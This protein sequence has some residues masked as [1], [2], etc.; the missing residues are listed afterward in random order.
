[1]RII[2]KFVR[3]GEERKGRAGANGERRSAEAGAK[4]SAE[5]ARQS[6]LRPARMMSMLFGRG[7][8]DGADASSRICRRC[9]NVII[10]VLMET[11]GSVF[12]VG[13]KTKGEFK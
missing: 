4:K 3:R 13:I 5:S 10:I 9:P 6:R 8:A 1:M 2:L 11:R 7:A 12:R